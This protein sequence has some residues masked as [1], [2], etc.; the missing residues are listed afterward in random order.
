MPWVLCQVVKRRTAQ[1]DSIRPVP[2]PGYHT[3]C[4][5][6]KWSSLWCL[7]RLCRHHLQSNTETTSLRTPHPNNEGTDTTPCP[8]K[9][10][11][12]GWMGDSYISTRLPMGR[13]GQVL[14]KYQQDWVIAESPR[15]ETQTRSPL[16]MQRPKQKKMKLK[17]MIFFKSGVV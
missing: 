12:T 13:A 6:I 8:K 7:V 4:M 2:F 15:V 10:V 17:L 11:I 5:P 9:A 3:T 1:K 14:N 16:L